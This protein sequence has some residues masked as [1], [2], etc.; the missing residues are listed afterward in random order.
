MLP[1]HQNANSVCNMMYL[2]CISGLKSKKETTGS[3]ERM[4]DSQGMED[5]QDLQDSVV[6][7]PE[8]NLPDLPSSED[9]SALTAIESCKYCQL[10][11]NTSALLYYL[12]FSCSLTHTV[13]FPA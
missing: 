10:I 1:V 3:S 5:S 9:F 13:V 2:P 6:Y 11:F 4:E 7:H 12:F 8:D